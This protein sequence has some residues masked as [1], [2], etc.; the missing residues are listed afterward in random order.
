MQQGLN[1]FATTRVVLLPQVED[2]DA[3][4]RFHQQCLFQ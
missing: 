1:D 3:L 4:E 2:W